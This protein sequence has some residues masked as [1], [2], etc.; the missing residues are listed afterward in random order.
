MKATIIMYHYIRDLDN[1]RYPKIKGLNI[2]Q[3]K[4]QLKYLGRNYNFVNVE[5]II[6]ALNNNTKLPPKAVLL[7]F[8]DAY[9][10]HFNIV[11]PILDRLKIQGAFYPP[12]KAI[13]KN[14]V[15]DVNKI[16][17][18][19]ASVKNKDRIIYEIK[20]QIKLFKKEY[21]LMSFNFY[22]KKLAFK[23]GYDSAKVIFIKRFLQV[24]LEEK[25]RNVMVNYL[26]NK[27]IKIPEKIFS[28]EL[29][30]NVEQIRCMRRNGMHIGVH[31][32]EHYWFNSISKGKQ[33]NEIKKSLQ[34]QRK[35]GNN[36]EKWT[37]CY[38]Y[39]AYNNN[40]LE[41]LNKYK[42]SFAL[43]T[44]FG[45]STISYKNRLTLQ[46]L[47]TN[48]IPKNSFAKTNNWFLKS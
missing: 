2:H 38:P 23:W 28:K 46:R 40:T 24:E 15:L 3:F 33:E 42:C 43:T 14:V 21:N 32:Y 27:F 39:G 35:I 29:Y 5:N 45:V 7:T 25:L 30:M 37:M 11:F 31:G 17:F 9:I 47:D 20:K 34:F 6:E 18:I 12:V 1:S 36:T 19:L 16:H 22:Y 4:E 13:E 41:L 8:D 48:Q 26:F 44:N 10:D